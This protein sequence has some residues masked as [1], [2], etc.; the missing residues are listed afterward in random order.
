V[1]NDTVF[2]V[3]PYAAAGC[4]ALGFFVRFVAAG[5][6]GRARPP[7]PL[8]DGWKLLGGRRVWRIALGLVLVA[9]LVALLAP[10]T[11]A[12]WNRTPGRLYLLE[13]VGLLLGALALVGLTGGLRRFLGGPTRSLGREVTDAVFLASLTLSVLVGLT[14]AARY[15]WASLWSAATV[16][17]Y[18]RSLIRANPEPALMTGTPMLAQLH[19]VAG[20]TAVAILPWSGLGTTV[21][22]LA[23]RGVRG[24]MG[25]IDAGAAVVA[26]VVRLAAWAAWLWPEEDLL[27]DA[28]ARRPRPAARRRAPRQPDLVSHHAP[29][30]ELPAAGADASAVRDRD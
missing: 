7:V 24:A 13:G 25:L 14:V 22:L 9:H 12:R 11:L 27:D 4:A 16:V 8:A 2:C 10:E 29:L 18:L 5:L 17:P 3:A 23:A 21:V 15:R 26:R 6:P 1:N 19:V 30:P 20:L 28:V